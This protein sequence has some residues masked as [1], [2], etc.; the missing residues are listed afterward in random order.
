MTNKD[1][2]FSYLTRIWRF[3]EFRIIHID[4]SPH[5]IALGVSLGMFTAFLPLMGLHTI[6]ALLLTF[7]TRAN[8]A[9]S[10]LC[11]WISN[12]F[13]II[14][15]Y[16]PCY[17]MG[18]MIVGIFR[19]GSPTKTAEVTEFLKQTLSLSRLTSTV[20]SAEF[21]KET[22]TLFGKIGLELTTGCLICGITAAIV[23]YFIIFNMIMVHRVKHQKKIVTQKIETQ[24]QV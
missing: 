19:N 17:L 6:I 18:R 8:K 24:T 12:P 23:S 13:T 20:T 16:L 22:A 14:P 10:V 21:W 2:K 4:D 5:R 3:I 7:I 9:V 11:S 15:I 1:K